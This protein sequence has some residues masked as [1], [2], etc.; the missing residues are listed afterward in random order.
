MLKRA[1]RPRLHT[2]LLVFYGFDEAA[3][4]ISILRASVICC[5]EAQG[6][7]IEQVGPYRGLTRTH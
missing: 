7:T 3:F 4:A 5:A 6:N 2:L 1:V